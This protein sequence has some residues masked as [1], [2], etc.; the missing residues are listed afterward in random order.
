[1]ENNVRDFLLNFGIVSTFSVLL[2]LG[3]YGYP[4]RTIEQENVKASAIERTIH[5]SFDGSL[6][7]GNLVDENADGIADYSRGGIVSRPNGGEFRNYNVSD[8]LQNI[9]KEVYEKSKFSR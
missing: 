9:Y 6:R 5:K 3:I 7:M 8:S 2:A 1:M 4:A